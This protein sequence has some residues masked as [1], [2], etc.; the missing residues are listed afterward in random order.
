MKGVAEFRARDLLNA[1]VEHIE[2]AWR[3]P[4]DG[5]WEVRGGSRHFVHS[6]IMSWVAV[7]RMV[8]G[9]EA[10][11]WGVEH[12][13]E[14]LEHLRQ[15]RARMHD[16]I[17]ARGFSEKENAFVQAFDSDVLDASALLIP[18]L[19]FLPID[20]PRVQGTIHAV[21]KRLM[22]D[23]LVLRYEPAL[24]KDGVA[25]SEG[26]FIPC[27][28]WLVDAYAASGRVEEAV[29]LF[30]RALAL[31]NDLGLLAEEYETRTHRQTGNYPQAFSHLA[32]I[33]SARTIGEAQQ[34]RG[35]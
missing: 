19:D 25:G 32:L 5:I 3:R 10:G 24:G 9:S 22:R 28:F 26:V 18:R 27:T 1:M 4:D 15:L 7:D 35:R 23:G 33:H 17:C 14:R 2:L 13:P 29:A 21:E 20:D 8:R 11:W 30:E 31:R 6:K 12:E 16:E 34:A